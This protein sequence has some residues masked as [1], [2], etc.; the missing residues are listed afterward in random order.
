[1]PTE[2]II[3]QITQSRKNFSIEVEN[4]AQENDVSLFD[5]LSHLCHTKEIEP[6]SAGSLISPTLKEKM[7]IELSDISLIKKEYQK[8]KAHMIEDFC[9]SET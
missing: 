8:R 3:E 1:M 2:T 5:A 9:Q 4:F 6:E 7:L